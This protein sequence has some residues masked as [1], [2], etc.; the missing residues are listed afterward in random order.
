MTISCSVCSPDFKVLW[1]SKLWSGCCW[2]QFS[3]T[4]IEHT[5]TLTTGKIW[6]IRNIIALRILKGTYKYDNTRIIK[7]AFTWEDHKQI[8]ARCLLVSSFCMQFVCCS[9]TNSK[10]ANAGVTS[11]I[12][13]LRLMYRLFN[14][15][16]PFTGYMDTYTCIRIYGSGF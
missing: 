13:R 2:N 8:T 10:G 9:C 11:I 7:L 1:G 12:L 6:A 3:A 16:L 5:W 4:P 14:N 15:S